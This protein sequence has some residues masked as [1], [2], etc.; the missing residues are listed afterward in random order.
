MVLDIASSR[1]GRTVLHV[2]TLTGQL[3]YISNS[4]LLRL[5]IV[6]FA[7]AALSIGVAVDWSAPLSSV[8]Y[9]AT[10]MFPLIL[11]FDVTDRI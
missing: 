10:S 5:F 6:A 9:H 1:T 7:N 2:F 3:A 11:L 4:P 8:G